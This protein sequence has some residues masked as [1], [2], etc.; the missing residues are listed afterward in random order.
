MHQIC[1]LSTSGVLLPHPAPPFTVLLGI[2]SM[3]ATTR[4]LPPQNHRA[5]ALLD[6]DHTLFFGSTGA[7]EASLEL[8]VSLLE[9]LSR[10]G[11]TDVYLFTDMT[12]SSSSV[13]ERR[14][15]ADILRSRY[16]FL[17]HGYITPCD[18]TWNCF[19]AEEALMLHKMCMVDNLYLGK[20]FG[21]DFQA[22]IESHAAELPQI[23]RAVAAY[24]PKENLPGSAF[25]DAI[26]EADLNSGR[27]SSDTT[28]RSL[29]AKALGD[30]IADN[31]GFKHSKGLMLDLFLRHAPHW[32]GSVFVCDDNGSVCETISAF[33]P[34]PDSR[35][36]AESPTARAVPITML[37]VT[38]LDMEGRIYTEALDEHFRKTHENCWCVVAI[39]FS[40][41]SMSR[42]QPAVLL[43]ALPPGTLPPQDCLWSIAMPTAQAA[44]SIFSDGAD[45]VPMLLTALAASDADSVARDVSFWEVT[46]KAPGL[47]NAV[48]VRWEVVPRPG[49]TQ[50]QLAALL[51]SGCVC[52][53][54]L[55]LQEPTHGSDQP[56]EA[57]SVVW[58][59]SPWHMRTR[60]VS[61]SA[62]S[63]A[64]ARCSVS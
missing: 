54:S 55:Q 1:P 39:R 18:L 36:P 28:A 3:T 34:V 45:S 49:V 13:S 31:L 2:Q 14:E 37:R 40:R 15:L 62:S 52:C 60:Q 35:L 44:C 25:A 32:V 42:E 61:S 29:F 56:R 6:V 20:F 46:P 63:F 8:N 5:V 57:A 41:T 12:L 17:L 11:I 16:G 53:S 9:A 26:L 21:P 4:T 22:F 24:L 58:R 48:C 64:R 10:H 7:D 27:V 23:S 47:S 50:E 30:H 51:H 43:A 59:D 33:E 38:G 19:G